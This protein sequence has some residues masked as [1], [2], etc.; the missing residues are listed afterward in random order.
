[1]P[2]DFKDVSN[3]VWMVTEY[4]NGVFDPR[5]RTV[6]DAEPNFDFEIPYDWAHY[7]YNLPDGEEV[8]GNLAIKG[9]IDL[10]TK[11]DDNTLE[12]VD[13]K[14]GQRKNWATG[15]EKDYDALC[16]DNQLMLYYYAARKMYPEY[17]NIMVSI[18]FVRH[19][20][21]FTVLFDD[22]TVEKVESLLREKFDYV[23]NCKIP[24][25]LDEK[26]RDFRCT[27]ICDFYK[28]K[29]GNSNLCKVIHDR[30]KKFGMEKTTADFIDPNH[31]ISKYEA[32]G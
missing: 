30:I 3:F 16:K 31:K 15:E 19:G 32:P 14:T 12:I 4:N 28:Q 2:V 26:Q 6:V 22:S 25:M 24:K 8:V 5:K 21:P 11:V 17:K 29:M 9:T 20:G 1:M 27:R 10:I 7:Y 18:F 23:R 13:W